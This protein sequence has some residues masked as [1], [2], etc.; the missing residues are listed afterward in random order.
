MQKISALSKFSVSILTGI[1]VVSTLAMGA[2]GDDSDKSD[3]SDKSNK[4]KN[5]KYAN[6]EDED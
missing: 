4:T 6:Y 2:Y 5:E 3:K 1:L